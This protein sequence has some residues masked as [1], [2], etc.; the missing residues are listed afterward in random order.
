MNQNFIEK[1]SNLSPLNFTNIRKLA[2]EE[3]N[4]LSKM[5]KDQLCDDFERS[6]NQS[7]F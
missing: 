6:L 5:E 7:P 2:N 4:H 1:V 3:L